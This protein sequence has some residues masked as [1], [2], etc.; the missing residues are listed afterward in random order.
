VR[1]FSALWAGLRVL[2]CTCQRA[3]AVS[4]VRYAVHARLTARRLSAHLAEITRNATYTDTA[5]LS[6]T[7]LSQIMLDPGTGLVV[8]VGILGSVIAANG[9]STQATGCNLTPKYTPLRPYATA[10]YIEGLAVLASV[11]TDNASQW[12]DL[13]V[14]SNC[15]ACASG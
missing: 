13:C 2:T 4:R 15:A 11:D 14:N 9:V 5:A 3:P 10:M 7:F 6:A 12:N 1:L 8:E